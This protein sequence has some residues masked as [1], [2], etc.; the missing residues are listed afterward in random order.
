MV[1]MR[2]SED[3]GREPT[4]RVILTLAVL[5]AISL[6]PANAQPPEEQSHQFITRQW[7]TNDG[8]PQNS[9][10]A[11]LQDAQGYLWIATYGG[12]ARFDGVRFE[13]F[14]SADNPGLPNDRILTVS[15]SNDGRL[16]VGT[17]ESGIAY[18]SEGIFT[19]FDP[20]DGMGLKGVNEI[21]R[22]PSGTLWIG[23]AV[24]LLRLDTSGAFTRFSTADGLPDPPVYSF[25][26]EADGTLWVGTHGGLAVLKGD[27]FARISDSR[28]K[29]DRVRAIVPAQDGGFWIGAGSGL[30]RA[31]TDHRLETVALPTALRHQAVRCLLSDRMGALWI[32]FEFAGLHHIVT[33]E[34][35]RVEIEKVSV[36]ENISS[37]FE[38]AEGSIWVGTAAD[39]LFRLTRP[40]FT[41]VGR[42]GS[43]LDIPTIPIVGD[44]HG[45]VWIG[46]NCNG[47]FHFEDGKTTQLGR[48]AG[49][50]DLCVWSLLRTNNGDLWIGALDGE[51]S[52]LHGSEIQRLKIPDSSRKTVRALYETTNGTILV[53][54]DSG[55]FR[56]N[57]ETDEFTPI[58]RT[59]DLGI[60]FI[61]EGEDDALW[62]G[63][64]H[65]L[66][67]FKGLDHRVWNRANGLGSSI[68]RAVKLD[69]DGTVWIGTYGA[70]LYLLEQDRLFHF[71]THNGLPENIVSRIIEDELGRFWMTGNR[72]VT[73]VEKSDLRAVVDGAPG[74]I[75]AQLFGKAD[76]M[77]E[78][79][80]NGGGQP[81]GWLSHEGMLWIPTIKGI[82][83]VDTRIESRNVLPPPVHITRVF[84]NGHEVDHS[85]KSILPPDSRNLEIHYTALSY[86][87]PP[88]VRF[89][90][91]L[92]GVD[93]DWQDA[94]TRRVAYYPFLP[95]GHYR[96][97]V[98]ACN[99]DCIWN[100]E[101]DSFIFEVKPRFVQTPWFFLL[102][103]L[104]IAG[105]VGGF[106]RFRQT[107]LRQREREL[108]SLVANRTMELEELAALVE[109][110]NSA[111]LPEEILQFVF[112]SFRPTIPYDRIG[113]AVITADS[114]DVR[115]VW[116]RN[117]TG[118]M[119]LEKDFKA[120]LEGSSLNHL[121]ETNKPRIINDLVAYLEA[122]PTSEST[123]RIVEE[124]MRS[125]LTCPMRTHAQPLGFLF[126]SSCKLNTYRDA[127]IRF[128]SQVAAQL[129]VAIERSRLYSDLLDTQY[130]LQGA[131]KILE[132]LAS[133][134]G[135]TGLA[136]RRTF[137]AQ[138]VEEWRRS[139]R[140]G[141]PLSLMMIDIDHFKLFNDTYGHLEGDNCLLRFATELQSS[142]QRAGDSVGRYGGEEFTVILP[143]TTAHDATLAADRF[144]KKLENLQIPHKGSPSSPWVTA[145]IGIATERPRPGDQQN[146]LI[147]HADRALYRA[148]EAGRNRYHHDHKHDP[149]S[150]S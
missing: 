134:D 37:L 109:K 39:G 16:S 44:G 33:G 96:F 125:S 45:G 100:M 29:V 139:L 27:V 92:E 57:P 2:H 94:G 115:A 143:N 87:A 148:K 54:T 68:V 58:E 41:S 13:M 102:L 8:L 67:M 4:I 79:E 47:L 128:F 88:K 123:K 77:L 90:Y 106:M 30:F 56:L 136:N 140:S 75:T 114:K 38:D 64:N 48:E 133:Q 142:F 131:N 111:H 147:L 107:E 149:E 113:F 51:L 15:S 61:T 130:R 118:S 127:H 116:A 31:N 42:P 89:R 34:I 137:D 103:I 99:N 80:C 85:E 124:G 69:S 40:R 3:C 18:Y 108:R 22:G 76:G 71:G 14:E 141:L 24:D 17:E 62:L 97:D 132:G 46:T 81:A 122:H 135:L 55:A 7:T 83:T 78:N 5:M 50:H 9:V 150:E 19:P 43:L 60:Y 12:L 65:G 101:G 36:S 104:V 63:T 129:S 21:Y 70:G 73:M 32:G 49:L 121:L 93:Q 35:H 86:V 20:P 98:I 91:R 120:A 95:P 25:V 66:H 126:F 105:L 117:D 145:S 74:L 112:D 26:E 10:N 53:G 1:G 11:I 146:I 28:S 84:S 110:I 23:T 119:K 52:R 138:L 59:S 144:L 6:S 72:G 82:A